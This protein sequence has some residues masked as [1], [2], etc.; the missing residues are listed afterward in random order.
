[1]VSS[2]IKLLFNIEYD[3]SISGYENELIQAFLNIINNSKD[4][5]LNKQKNEPRY[6]FVETKNDNN[7]ILLTFKDNGGGIGEDILDKIFEPYFT[8]K[9]QSQGTGI[10]L[11]MTRKIVVEQNG[12]TLNVENVEFEY[13]GVSYR[14][15]SFNIIL[16]CC[17]GV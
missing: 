5:L 9:H 14:G 10:G 4:V 7:N 17:N 11:Y 3:C 2:E 8:T 16:K 15:A 12:G 1:M 6:I 13:E